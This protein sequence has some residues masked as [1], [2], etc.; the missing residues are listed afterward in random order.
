M[1][2]ASVIET[3]SNIPVGTIIA[4]GSSLCAI[5]GAIYAMIAKMYKTFEKYKDV[6]EE[7]DSLKSTVAKNSSD[8]VK[9]NEKI[10]SMNTVIV[11]KLSGI[12][13]RLESQEQTKI[14]ELRNTLV[15]KGEEALSKKQISIRAWSSLQEMFDEYENKYHQNSYVKSLRMRIERD[16]EVVGKLDEHGYDIEED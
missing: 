16:V 15:Y 1:N 4:W 10:E 9:L 12:E 11:Q 5:I 3:L 13:D 7:N 6:K 8:I 14:K 2:T